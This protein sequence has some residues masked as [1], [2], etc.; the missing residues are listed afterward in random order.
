MKKSA[1][2]ATL[3]QKLSLHK[4]SKVVVVG[5]GKTGFSVVKFLHQYG[6]QYAVVDSMHKPPFYD[7]A[8]KIDP[9]SMVFTGGFDKNILATATHLM[10]SPGISLHKKSI[11][12]VINAPTLPSNNSQILKGDM[13]AK[14]NAKIISDIDLF[15]CAT[16]Q[17]IIAITGS[18]GKSTV[19]TMLQDMGNKSGIKTAVGGNLDVPALDLLAESVALYVLELSSFQLERTST[20]NATAA[21]V[22]NIS[23]DHLDRHQHLKQYIQE[24]QKVF[25]GN[26]VMVLNDDDAMVAAMAVSHRNTLTFSIHNNSG[27][28]LASQQGEAWLMDDKKYLMKRTQLPLIGQHNVANALCAFAL[29]KAVGLNVQDMC[30]ALRAFKGLPHRMQYVARVNGVTWVNDSKATNIGACIA[31]LQTYDSAGSPAIILIAG[32][33]AKGTAMGAEVGTEMSAEMAGL[34]ATL[35]AKTKCVVLLG[36]DAQK[37]AIAIN[38]CVPTH[39]VKTIKEAVQVAAQIALAGENV[40]LSPA[41]ASIDQFKNYAER[42]DKFT[43]AVLELAA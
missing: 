33:D 3:K 37:I 36:K 41:C 35:K 7:A 23:T 9:D 18:N 19:T 29:G 32:G 28:H 1:V 25:A 15:S 12:Q 22:L 5:L 17:P 16:Q 26:G 10:V 21:T 30:T 8:L 39:L 2:L 13:P 31:A 38:N 42:G 27:F 24:K 4:T 6:I 40:V 20:L 34:V 14:P 11:Q 43:E